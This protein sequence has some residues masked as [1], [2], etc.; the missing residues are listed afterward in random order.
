MNDNRPMFPFEDKNLTIRKNE[1]NLLET[2]VQ[3]RASDLDLSPQFG[4]QSLIYSINYCMPNVYKVFV[5]ERTGQISSKLVIDL[6]T[7]EIIA[8]R[9]EMS[10]KLNSIRDE[11]IESRIPSKLINLNKNILNITHKNLKQF[12]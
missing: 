4:N 2:L 5:D 10:T 3:I 1:S 9:R 7:D 12:A 6:D 8:K 11:D